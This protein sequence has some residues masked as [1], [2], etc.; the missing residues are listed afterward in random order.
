MLNRR[1]RAMNQYTNSQYRF[2][3]ILPIKNSLITLSVT[4]WFRS[5]CW[6]I[7]K[8]TNKK[9]CIQ[10]LYANWNSTA[11]AVRLKQTHIHA[12]THVFE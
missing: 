9:M 2:G 6:K 11:I 7:Y 4:S 8:V 12:N 5:I 1:D 3:I 10:T